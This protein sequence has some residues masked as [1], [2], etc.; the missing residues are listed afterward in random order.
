MSKIS[1]FSQLDLERTYS[2][3]DYLAWRFD[4]TVELL[5]GK[6]SLMRPA[7]NLRHQRISKNLLVE[8]GGY[9]KGKPC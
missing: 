4:E 9:L 6:V 5:R 2:Y 3:A 1:H 7:P 8:I